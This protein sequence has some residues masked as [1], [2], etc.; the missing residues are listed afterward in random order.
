M[1]YVGEKLRK[2]RIYANKRCTVYTPYTVRRNYGMMSP[3]CLLK[4]AV[5]KLGTLEALR[6]IHFLGC[7]SIIEPMSP[8]AEDR[9]Q[10][11]LG[12]PHSATSRHGACPVL[13]RIAWPGKS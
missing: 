2:R 7:P 3:F 1:Q 8:Y 5:S 6:A 10:S 9:H 4:A 12:C 11:I 13:P